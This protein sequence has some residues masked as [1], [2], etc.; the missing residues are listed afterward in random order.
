MPARRK[1][2][3]RNTGPPLPGPTG[4]NAWR[5]A[6]PPIRIE[7]SRA[8]KFPFPIPL[9]RMRRTISLVGIVA[10]LIA[11]PTLAEAQQSLVDDAGIVATGACQLE[12]WGWDSGSWILPACSPV[13]GLELTL[14]LILDTGGSTSTDHL[15]VAEVKYLF[16]DGYAESWGV[17]IVAGGTFAASGGSFSGGWVY[18]PFTLSVGE[19]PLTLHAN[20]GWAIE[21]EEEGDHHHDHT[22]FLWGVNAEVELTPRISGYGELL[23]VTGDGAGLQMGLAATLIPQR[24]A[25]EASYG[26]HLTESEEGTGFQLGFAWTPPPFRR[27]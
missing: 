1:C 17:G 6:E 7:L 10:T 4:K 14:G 26:R 21:R 13:S 22:G 15:G 5:V 25:V 18:A 11:A 27:R 24:L 19:L 3:K 16:R 23:G 20:L 2:L 9:P 8:R 12:V